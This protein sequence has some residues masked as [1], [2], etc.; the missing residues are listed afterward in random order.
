MG[1]AIDAQGLAGELEALPIAPNYKGFERQLAGLKPKFDAVN[2]PARYFLATSK[3]ANFSNASA[4]GV[5]NALEINSQGL[6]SKATFYQITPLA[7]SGLFG[8]PKQYGFCAVE[9]ASNGRCN[10]N[11]N[12]RGM[13]LVNLHLQR[14]NPESKALED[15]VHADFTVSQN[16]QFLLKDLPVG[17]Y[18]WQINFTVDGQISSRKSGSFDLIAIAAE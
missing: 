12:M 7:Q 18:H 10:V 14:L 17:Q 6:E 8:E 15:V 16:D 5:L 11:F 9:A 4:D 2:S 3:N 13:Q 1:L